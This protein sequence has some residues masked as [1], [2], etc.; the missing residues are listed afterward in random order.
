[1]GLWLNAF[2]TLFLK[3]ALCQ[4]WSLWTPPRIVAIEGCCLLIPCRFE[5]PAEYEAQFENCE[6]TGTWKINTV[7]GSNIFNSF[8]TG[9]QKNIKGK[10]VGDLLKKNCT[11]T[12]D[13]LNAGRDDTYS[14]RL[15]C[16]GTNILKYNFLETV[17]IIHTDTPPKPQLTPMGD[18][19]EGEEVRLRCS[20]PAPCRTMP[21]SLTWNYGH[22]VGVESQL[23]EGEDGLKMVTSILTF[24][25]SPRH[26]RMRVT[27]SARYTM[28][29]GGASKM[30][31]SN[32]TINVLC[33]REAALTT[34]IHSSP[35][36][37][38]APRNIVTSATPPG[39]AFEGESKTLTCSSDANPPVENYSWYKNIGGQPTWK[40]NG[41]ILVLQVSKADSGLYLCEAQNQL[42]SQ[43]SKVMPLELESGLCL[44]TDLYIISGVLLLL[45]LLNLTANMYTFKSLSRR[46]NMKLL[47]S[48]KQDNTYQSLRMTSISPE[49]DQLQMTR[50]SPSVGQK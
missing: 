8:L 11:T 4:Q 29:P 44:T 40:A 33:K 15:E 3:G 18:F 50:A 43:R 7:P 47:L 45:G 48:K 32:Q 35:S 31:Q 37:N 30:A 6:P 39:P 12:F 27:C 34:I 23:Q 22:G 42:G 25:A 28:Q 41:Q 10:I 1:M 36:N 16:A 49:Y 38:N 24:T 9:A 5:I 17:Q 13:S 21:P 26:H 19:M 46:V 20:A 2:T 14:F